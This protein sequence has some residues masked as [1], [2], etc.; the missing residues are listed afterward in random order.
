MKKKEFLNNKIFEGT[1][2]ILANKW[3]KIAKK[4]VFAI[5][6]PKWVRNEQKFKNCHNF[7]ILILSVHL[8]AKKNQKWHKNCQKWQKIIFYHKTTKM[9]AKVTK[10]QNCHQFSRLIIFLHLWAKKAKNDTKIAKHD[11]KITFCYK[12]IR[13]STKHTK[14]EKFSQFLYVLCSFWWVYSKK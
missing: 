3:Q 5:N 13:M 8:L 4:L 7:S 1:F 9:S 12:H 10:I 14:I 6:P 2:Q 11:K